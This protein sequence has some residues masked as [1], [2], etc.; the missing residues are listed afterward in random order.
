MSHYLVQKS[1]VPVMV[2]HNK[3]KLPE[4]PRGKADVVNNVRMRHMRLD[5]AA[6]EKTSTAAEHQDV[7]GQEGESPEEHYW[8][9]NRKSLARRPAHADMHF[10]LSDQLPEHEFVTD[11][12]QDTARRVELQHHTHVVPG[13]FRNDQ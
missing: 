3:L 7:P 13:S 12:P 11:D 9:L 1:S 5:Q 4:L 6:V 10:P 2:A 8:R